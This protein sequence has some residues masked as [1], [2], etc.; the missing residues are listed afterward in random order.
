MN[1]EDSGVNLNMPEDSGKPAQSEAGRSQEQQS[2]KAHETQEPLQ[3]APSPPPAPAAEQQQVQTA[4]DQA[5]PAQQQAPAKTESTKLYSSED[6][7]N[8]QVDLEEAGF[9]LNIPQAAPKA[10]PEPEKQQ[11]ESVVDSIVEQATVSE[12]AED[13]ILK[14]LETMDAE[15]ELDVPVAPT[16]GKAKI[17]F[18]AVLTIAISVFGYLF[19][20][21]DVEIGLFG[22]QISASLEPRVQQVADIRSQTITNHYSIAAIALRDI[23]DE[24]AKYV[25]DLYISR[26]NFEELNKQIS[27]ESRLN[28]YKFQIQ[29]NLEIMEQEISAA[30]KIQAADP[31]A[32]SEV[33]LYLSEQAESEQQPFIEDVKKLLVSK[34]ILGLIR[35][36]NV[37]QMSDDELLAFLELVIQKV[38]TNDMSRVAYAQLRRFSWTE[39]ITALENATSQVDPTLESV[40]YTA[41]S[42]NAED[43]RISV[44]GQTRTTGPNTF[45]LITELTEALEESFATNVENRSF[46]KSESSE[47]GFTSTIRLEFNLQ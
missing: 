31:E 44:T 45:T 32:D 12:E 38:Q 16:A 11:E 41:Y 1:G 22:Q 14:K 4:E 21:A 42:F 39:I 2:V 37:E 13:K 18:F 30:K 46:T 10:G 19:L 35:N 3:Q 20:G 47:D 27:A 40:T 17:T 34:E 43:R 7:S 36:A 5:E 8:K 23:A 6:P 29:D 26:S 25:N 33:L 24:T 9:D 15:L 28:E